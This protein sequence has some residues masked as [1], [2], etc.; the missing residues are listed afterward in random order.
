MSRP[1]AQ[2]ARRRGFAV[3]L[4]GCFSAIMLA[5]LFIGLFDR[6]RA[7]TNLIWVANGVLLAFLL[8]APRW[9]WGAYLG[10]GF[11]GMFAAN[12]LIHK[13]WRM[14]LLS[15]LLNLAEVAIGALLVR[16]RSMELPRFSERSYLLR[17][18]GFAVLTGP[19]ATG[20]IFTLVLALWR[21][22][23]PIDTFLLWT[24]GDSLGIAIATPI[25]VAIFRTSLG[26]TLTWKAFWLY[27]APLATVTIG[28][29]AQVRV[30]L[31]FLIYPLLILVLLNLE[32]GWAAMATLLVVA[33][34]GWYTAHRLG[35]FAEMVSGGHSTSTIML[36]AFVAAAVFM[37]YSVSVILE[38]KKASERKLR[39]IAVL[40]NLVTDNSRD[41]IILDDIHGCHTYIS[42]ASESMGGWTPEEVRKQGSFDLVHPDDME[43]AKAAERDLHSGAEG[44]MIEIRLRKKN[45]EYIWVES[46]LRLIVDPATNLPTGILNIVRDISERKSTEQSREF[47]LS[48]IRAIYE[49]SLDGIF[50]VDEEGNVLSHNKRFSDIWKIPMPDIPDDPQEQIA[51]ISYESLLSQAADRVKD[52]EA[53]VKRVRDIHTDLDTKGQY[54]VELKDGR[55]LERYATSLRSEMGRNLGRVVFFRDITERRRTEQSREFHLS[56]IR[57]I[58][59]AS[60]DGVLVV[61]NEGSVALINK[62]F[63]DVWKI[64]MPYMPVNLDERV[65]EI[66]HEQLVSQCVDLVKNPET[67]L[68]LVRGLYADPNA[69][70][71]CEVEL[72]DGRTL[73]R[74]STSLRSEAGQYLARVWFYRDISERKNTEQSREF[75]LSLI[76]A[77]YE[78]SLDG[79]LVVN[80]EGDVVSLNKRFSEIWKLP[81]SDISERLHEECFFVTDELLL[82]Q[83]ADR[84]KDPKAFIKRIQE[85][86][87]DPDENDQ[88]HVELKDG[89]TLERYSASLRSNQGQHFGRVWFFR[90]ISE[91]MRT[92]QK[93]QEAYNTVESLAITDALTGLANRRRF[94]QYLA[95][96]WGRSMRVHS[97]L[98]LLMID[99]DFFKRHNDI[100][101]HPRGDNCLKQVAEA[102]QDVVTRPGDLIARFGG[103]EFAV[104]LPNTGNDGAMQVAREICESMS[105]RG[106]PHSGN[107]RGIVTISVGCATLVP[108][109][110]QHSSNLV[111]LADGALYKAKQSGRDH[112]CNANTMESESLADK[113]V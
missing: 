38:R 96:E 9:R 66:P 104:I 31:L 94:D 77:I 44:V 100:Y 27:L 74:H 93:L 41:V 19:V 43:I 92:K 97:L 64:S 16:R 108:S 34:G 21:H 110:G 45:G 61:N 50:V 72:K 12:A 99:V 105:N 6:Q 3:H 4:A 68:K 58:F 73:E 106:L 59:E 101:G 86:Y 102:V 70:D 26:N 95:T 29:F 25:C 1:L 80:N 63:A 113:P 107:P 47:Q 82:S 67:F 17:F 51:P 20:L 109:F 7:F 39:E 57:A 83:V 15:C 42:A 2:W 14:N 5:V 87:A 23:A 13:E 49:V 71:H 52:S 88:S 78:V 33:A 24:I 10:A 30:P 84:L 76:R 37:I 91:L 75:Q 60:L 85:L 112:V 8:L 65:T 35:P 11:A 98:S 81:P 48:L 89:R 54:Q 40:H 56:L 55:T 69:D 22:A 90:D 79:V 62:R 53:F 111:E 46:N 18:F 36:Q 28:A 32:L 103:D